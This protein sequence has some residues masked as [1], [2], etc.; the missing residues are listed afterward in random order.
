VRPSPRIILGILVVLLPSVLL[1]DA[2]IVTK[3]MTATTIAE[4]FV[5]EAAVTVDLEIGLPDLEGFPDLLP[6]RLYEQLGYAPQPLA[7]RLQ[8]F[9]REG[10]VVRSDGGPPLPGHV[11]GIE[12]RP[13]VRRDE[14]TGDPL[15]VS[16]EDEKEPVVFVRLAYPLERRPKRLTLKPPRNEPG[17]VSAN[18]GLVT[19]HR[20]LPVNDFRYLSSEETLALDWDDPWYSRFD[21]RNLR[22]QYDAPIQAFLYVDPFEVRKE[23]V[24]RPMDL[25]QWV[26]LGLEGKEIIPAAEQGALKGKI[27]EFLAGLSPV[28]I[29]GDPA[30]GE[31]DRIHFI[32]R[33]L[34]KTGIIDPPEDLDAI[35]ATVGIIFVYPIDG[36]P[37]EATLEWELWSDRIQRVP[38][39]A[40]DEAGGLPSILTPDDAVL[41][42][43]NF[44]TN[45]TVPGLVAVQAPQ[46]GHGLGFGI[47]AVLAGIALAT[48]VVRVGKRRREGARHAWG[49]LALLAGLL[50][51]AAL[52]GYRASNSSRVGD[53]DAAAIVESLLENVYRSFDYHDE[54]RIYDILEQ[55][56][57]GELLT[58]IYLETRRSLEIENQGGARA[59]VNEV[60]MVASEH[61]ELEGE[62]GFVSQSTWNVAGSV[63]HWGHIHQRRN[64]YLARVTV[65]A[66]EGAWKITDLELLQEERL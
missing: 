35:S 1:A 40:T 19:Y 25:Q 11:E 62:V 42:W 15:S 34:K 38:A 56:A 4:V 65:K 63:G 2:I 55:S 64:R 49:T 18:I 28:T 48:V 32:R 12:V 41:R 16:A 61:T 22:R 43:Q 9:F 24:V 39:I 3:A 21:N 46:A 5:E 50:V 66:I 6:D 8:R 37:E 14:I 33:S 53:E 31:L 59:K 17:T 20:G 29:D 60:E 26:D 51:V 47:I 45:P 23:I 10:F 13:R 30:R 7:E 52:A 36:L 58:E 44:L 27:A 54:S 57:A